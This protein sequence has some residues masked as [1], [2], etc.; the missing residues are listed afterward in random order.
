MRGYGYS[1]VII[2]LRTQKINEIASLS[3]IHVTSELPSKRNIIYL[4][5]TDEL[6]LSNCFALL[7]KMFFSSGLRIGAR[8]DW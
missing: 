6:N 3:K 8:H 2:Q 1:G 5:R 4:G 7:K